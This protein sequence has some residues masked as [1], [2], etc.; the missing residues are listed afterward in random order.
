MRRGIFDRLK[1]QS[2]QWQEWTGWLIL[3][4][5]VA[6]LYLLSLRFWHVV[7]LLLFMGIFIVLPFIVTIAFKFLGEG[8]GQKRD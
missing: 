5:Y 4:C 8:E 6:T 3:V 7:R 1:R 2:G